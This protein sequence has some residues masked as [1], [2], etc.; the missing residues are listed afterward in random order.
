MKVIDIVLDEVHV[1]EN[2]R[3]RSGEAVNLIEFTLVY[4]RE[5]VPSVATVKKAKLKDNELHRPESGFENMI[6]F[7]ESLRGVSQINIK[8]VTVDKPSAFE[9]FFNTIFK[10]FLTGALSAATGGVSNVITGKVQEAVGKSFIDSATELEEAKITIG[11]AVIDIDPN[12]IQETVSADL[13]V[14]NG[15]TYSEFDNDAGT[16]VDKVL[17]GKTE[18]TNQF[19]GY[20]KLK[21]TEAG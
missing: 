18:D 3:K 13:V 4:P 10:G 11:E 1:R 19:N 15:V 14:K 12:N 6:V 21:I 8:V 7:R 20:V 9:K 5:G 17:L 16:Y 2:G